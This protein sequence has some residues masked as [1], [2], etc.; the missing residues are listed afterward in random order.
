MSKKSTLFL[1]LVVLIL[2][3]ISTKRINNVCEEGCR[4]CDN[5]NQ[6][7]ECLQG[8]FLKESDIDPLIYHCKKCSNDCKTCKKGADLCTSCH[9]NYQLHFEHSTCTFRYKALGILAITIVGIFFF[10]ITFACIKKLCP[11]KCC[12]D[13]NEIQYEV[14][15]FKRSGTNKEEDNEVLKHNGETYD[16]RDESFIEKTNESHGSR[17]ERNRLV[18]FGEEV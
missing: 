11:C 15:K 10:L 14:K 12:L 9:D 8:Y 16:S 6:C 5:D 13:K 18:I 17:K 4:K 2:K 3:F 1:F 7:E